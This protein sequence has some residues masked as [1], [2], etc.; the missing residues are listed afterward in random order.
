MPGAYGLRE[1][2]KVC[3]NVGYLIRVRILSDKQL[4]MSK[5]DV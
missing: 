4:I 5:I 3:E 2:V 1:F